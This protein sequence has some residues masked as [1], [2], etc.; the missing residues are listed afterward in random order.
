MVHR[1]PLG[2]AVP[3]IVTHVS[4]LAGRSALPPTARGKVIPALNVAR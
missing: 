1:L 3:E 4:H 2:S